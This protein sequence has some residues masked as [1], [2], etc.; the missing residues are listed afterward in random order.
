MYIIIICTNHQITIKKLDCS[1]S[2]NTVNG[3]S[4][5]SKPVNEKHVSVFTIHPCTTERRITFSKKELQNCNYGL[6]EL[7]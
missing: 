5:K 3:N 7:N 4:V 2:H 6:C 1:F